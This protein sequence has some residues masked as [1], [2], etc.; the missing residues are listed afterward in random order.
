MTCFIIPQRTIEWRINLKNYYSCISD[1]TMMKERDNWC[2]YFKTNESC[3]AGCRRIGF[4][5]YDGRVVSCFWQSVS[6]LPLPLRTRFETLMALR[7][8]M[9]IHSLRNI[10]RHQIKSSIFTGHSTG[11]KASFIWLK[12]RMLFLFHIFPIKIQGQIKYY[13]KCLPA[14]YHFQ[15]FHS[16]QLFHSCDPFLKVQNKHQYFISLTNILFYWLVSM[17][18]VNK[19]DRKPQ[20]SK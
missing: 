10:L 11:S 17:K 5:T 14:N 15:L 16:E 13:F 20:V 12:N 18:T 3:I 8:T 4:L 2:S 6:S 7:M 1:I 9:D 19:N